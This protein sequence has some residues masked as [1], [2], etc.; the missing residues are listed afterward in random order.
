MKKTIFGKN[1][2]YINAGVL[3]LNLRKLKS[4]NMDKSWIQLAEKKVFHFMIK[5]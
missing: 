1:E 5:I 3:L 4:D 2:H